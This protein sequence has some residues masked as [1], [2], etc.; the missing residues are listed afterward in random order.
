M[1]RGMRG[2]NTMFL[3]SPLFPLPEGE[4]SEPM[5]ADVRISFTREAE[6]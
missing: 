5:R 2:E 4:G 1:S 3:P 6:L